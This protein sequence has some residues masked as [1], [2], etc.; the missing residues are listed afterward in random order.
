MQGKLLSQFESKYF[1]FEGRDA[2]IIYPSCPS[3]GKLM[4]KTQY[5]SAFPYFEVEMLRRGYTLC[6]LSHPT[7]W[8]P[9]SEIHVTAAF[10]RHVAAELGIEPKCIV[11]GMSCGGLQAVR[12]ATMYP[13]L[14]SVLFL[15]APVMNLL[16]LAGLG[17]STCQSNPIF[18]NEMVKTYGFTRSSIISFRKSPIDNMGPLIENNIPIIMLYGDADDVV[19]YEE[20]GQILEEYYREHGG[21]LKVMRM[22]GRGH[23]PH[24]LQDPTPIIEY[25]EAHL[26]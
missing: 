5:M 26:D 22:E 18:W 11:I 7:R 20:N 25:V 17:A 12:L 4:L 9:D 14:I 16:S 15:D 10:V 13:E 8:G 19:L 23:H 24:S 3:N 21:D 6:Y 2:M 1:F